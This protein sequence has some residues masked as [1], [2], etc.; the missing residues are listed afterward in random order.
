MA[1]AGRDVLARAKNGTGKTG[2]FLIPTLNSIDTT[3]RSVQALILVPTRELALQTAQI[4]KDLARHIEGMKV[5]TTTGGTPLRE[6]IVRLQQ[7]VHLI[8]ATPGR[9]LDLA[10][11]NIARLGACPLLVFDEADKLLSQD[12]VDKIDRII[13]F[14][15]GNRQLLLFSA[16]FPYSVKTFKDR[17]LDHTAYE[18]NLMESLTLRG[19][20]QFYAFVEERAKVH[21]LNTLF[22]KLQINQSIIFCNSVQRVELL[23]KKITELGA[24][25]APKLSPSHYAAACNECFHP[26]HPRT[27]C[28]RPTW[29]IHHRHERS[30]RLLPAPLFLFWRPRRAPTLQGRLLV[31]VHPQPHGAEGAQR[32]LPQFPRGALPQSGVFGPLH[33]RHRHPGRQ[34]RHQ[35]R[36]SRPC[37]VLP[38][39]HRPGWTLRPP[40][41]RRQSHHRRSRPSPRPKR[42]RPRS[43]ATPSGNRHDLYR[44]EQELGTTIQA[45]PREIDKSLYV[46]GI[47]GAAAGGAAEQ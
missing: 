1:L 44:I 16:T 35:L 18:I 38:P 23:A 26:I 27:P 36:L 31:H 21:C 14:L 41:R 13:S 11:K 3:K 42:P 6:D 15:P 20:T 37:R 8:V 4:A 33:P 12:Q 5:I 34:R 25:L 7:G 9:L 40:R 28:G 30:R 19:V 32:G 29:P 24:P 45:I 47:G 2:A 43:P 10:E 22:S 17:Y 46:A 39:P